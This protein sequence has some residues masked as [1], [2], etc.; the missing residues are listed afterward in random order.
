M[1]AKAVFKPGVVTAFL[2]QLDSVW[3]SS[4]LLWQ[5]HAKDSPFPRSLYPSVT[6]PPA[7]WGLSPAAPGFCLLSSSA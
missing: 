5:M 1:V 7:L 3:T 2:T 4:L 6:G